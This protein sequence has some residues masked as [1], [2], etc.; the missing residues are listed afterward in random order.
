MADHP[1]R[2]CTD[3]LV[4]KE[5]C[6][7]LLGEVREAIGKKMWSKVAKVLWATGQSVA[8]EREF[9]APNLGSCSGA[10]IFTHALL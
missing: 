3:N 1:A 7:L 2:Y 6:E 10:W 5:A 8:I 9:L 4:D